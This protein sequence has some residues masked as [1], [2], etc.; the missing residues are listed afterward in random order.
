LTGVDY[1]VAGGGGSAYTNAVGAYFWGK[2]GG[3]DGNGTGDE[4]TA[5][6]TYNQKYGAGNG[7]Q[8]TNPYGGANTGGGGGGHCRYSASFYGGNGGSGVVVI[9]W[10]T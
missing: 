9:Q 3:T 7:A 8:T 1:L 10:T 6:Q 5:G 2:G 4:A